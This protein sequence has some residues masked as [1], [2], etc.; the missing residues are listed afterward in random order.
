VLEPPPEVGDA[1]LLAEVRRAWDPDVDRVSYLAVGFGAHHWAAYVGAERTLFVTY[2]RTA[3]RNDGFPELEA[4]Y[5]GAVTLRD[6][7]LEF[8]I[9]PLRGRAGRVL[10]PF[11]R[12]A[13]SC[14]PW[15]DGTSEE[16]LDLAWT[17]AALRRLHA[18]A[19][20]TGL[21]RWRPKVGPD[22]AETL[23]SSTAR[24]WGP[25]PYADAARAGVLGRLDDTAR[26]TERY[27]HL[28]GVARAR[29]WVATHGEP[30]SDNQLLTA[31]GRFLIDWD[32]LR[33]APAEVDLRVLVEN[34]ARPDDVGADPE[35]L[36][37]FD[38]EWRLDEINQYA[39]W[40]AAPHT[41][42]RDDEIAFGGLLHELERPDHAA[43]SDG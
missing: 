7:G 21:V 35:M 4:A 41:G 36:E 37:L 9:A 30:H 14:T 2:D 29:P 42:S 24:G 17:I 12:G 16:P 19:P 32:T 27:H 6:R 25:G 33:L 20:P 43:S 39:A 11:A 3:G 38:L 28:A 40:F 34:G 15:R 31:D 23:A 22:L 10:V 18:T 26:W 1:D 13:L 5:D 8:V